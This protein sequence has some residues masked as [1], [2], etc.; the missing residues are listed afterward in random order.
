[1]SNCYLHNEN[2]SVGVC[3]GCGK[4]ICESCNT[5][6]KGKNYCKTCLEELFDENKKKVEKLEDS[7]RNQQQPM[8]FMNAGGASSS[9][10]SSSSSATGGH[11]GVPVYTKSKVA[12]GLLGIF[13]GSLGVHKFYIGKWVQGLIYLVF[14][15]TYIPAVVGFIEGIIYLV[16]SDESFAKKHDKG[17]RVV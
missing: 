5:E 2:P 9:A 15:W 1:M 16:S 3:I 12:A 8:V 11:H 13:L 14:F 4:F 6:I 10:S 17:Y 7:S